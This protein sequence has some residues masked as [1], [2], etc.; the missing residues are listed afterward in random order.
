MIAAG[1]NQ[2][3]RYELVQR[4]AVGGMAEVFLAKAYGAHGFEKTLAI[5][6][7]L[8]ELA[9]SREFVEH[10]IAEAKLAVQLNHGNIVQIF[11]FGR[12]HGTLFIAME[13]V[14]GLDLA[15]LIKRYRD[16]G[17]QIPLPAAFKI[18]IDIAAGLDFA[19]QLG[20]VHRDVSPSNIL[21]SRSGDVKIADF[22]IAIP[23]RDLVPDPDDDGR[24]SAESGR[25]RRRR[26]MGKWRYM[27]PEQ[28]RGGDVGTRS[29]LFSAAAVIFEIFTGR[30]LFAGSEPETI[31]AAIHHGEIPSAC[32][33]RPQLPPRF[34][35]ILG[36]ALARAPNARQKRAAELQRALME[37]SFASSVV[38]TA[39]EVADALTEVLAPGE[40]KRL[41]TVPP[42]R[43]VIDDFIR[44]QLG[45]LMG[46]GASADNVAHDLGAKE[47]SPD[48]T[49]ATGGARKTQVQRPDPSSSPLSS[50]GDSAPAIFALPN[51]GHGDA[52]VSSQ[53]ETQTGLLSPP[54]A[55]TAAASPNDNDGENN[56]DDDPQ[57]RPAT[58]VR[59]GVDMYGVG[60]WQLDAEPEGAANPEPT[61]PA[62]RQS[63]RASSAPLNQVGHDGDRQ[64][65]SMG[66]GHGYMSGHRA[67]TASPATDAVQER[68]TPVQ[69]SYRRWLV[70]LAAVVVAAGF[71]YAQDGIRA[72]LG[73][74]LGNN[75]SASTTRD[76]GAGPDN[77][78]DNNNNDDH[79]DD[80]SA[81]NDD[82]RGAPLANNRPTSGDPDSRPH[83]RVGDV[84]QTQPASAIAQDTPP[85]ISAMGPMGATGSM[86]VVSEPSGASVWLDHV[87]HIHTTPTLLPL[88]AGQAH[89]IEI[90]LAGYLPHVVEDAIVTAD[91]APATLR[92]ELD[93]MPVL[94]TF[95]TQPP[96]AIVVDNTG[97]GGR[98]L[99]TTP[100][101]EMVP[102]ALLTERSAPLTLS[103][104]GYRTQ[105]LGIVEDAV[106]GGTITVERT[107]RAVRQPS[108]I[109]QI[110]IEGSWAN[111]YGR[112]N[113][114]LG[115]A[116]IESLRLRAGKH[117]LRLHNPV[118]GKEQFIEV[119]VPPGGRRY[120]R[121]SM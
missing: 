119:D 35:D 98:Q 91:R 112:N 104:P 87:R 69:Q 114:P 62:S 74:A 113:R 21:I 79:N 53:I 33:L 111:I 36:Q 83:D 110:Y 75:P 30:K 56:S 7:I 48:M 109:V 101:S 80:N 82:E 39:V 63:P 19:H 34:D 37:L 43:M 41:N 106:P 96:G 24:D 59:T 90:R 105:R 77:N 1:Q 89:R 97:D 28:T 94:V 50:V 26:V 67:D 22:G 118:S 76:D 46:G 116:P 117:R 121:V 60:V 9:R 95:H 103:K 108:G 73:N 29:D 84:S 47:H 27:S 65:E 15:A 120:Y 13:H 14:N 8:P 78:N 2:L 68:P 115:R 71:I 3:E 81:D 61:P 17:Q 55:P 107:L 72:G 92:V 58:I 99:C 31:I 85:P 51:P 54:P 86:F 25:S 16:R 64:P 11:D 4:I 6:R 70:A 40:R 10:F 102:Y 66:S 18:A 100:C 38:A 44:D 93:A 52:D 88:T 45:G 23:D 20:V 12:V 5:K 49:T 32:A 57:E 42:R